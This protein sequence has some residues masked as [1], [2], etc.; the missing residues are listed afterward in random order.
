MGVFDRGAVGIA[1]AGQDVVPTASAGS[2]GR[3]QGSRID[4][5]GGGHPSRQDHTLGHLINVDPHW[6]A[7]R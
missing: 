1:C 7:L 2:L 6:N 4:L 3:L 5:H